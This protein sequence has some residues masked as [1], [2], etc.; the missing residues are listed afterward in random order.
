MFLL[1][2]L[3]SETVFAQKFNFEYLRV[4]PDRDVVLI[5]KRKASNL[6]FMHPRAQV[7]SVRPIFRELYNEVR[8]NCGFIGSVFSLRVVHPNTGNLLHGTWSASQSY[9]HAA[10]HCRAYPHAF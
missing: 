5:T 2:Q 10:K 1:A 7:K 8:T 6:L 3:Y 9:E 4:L